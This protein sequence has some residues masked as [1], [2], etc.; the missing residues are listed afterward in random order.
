MNFIVAAMSVGRMYAQRR[1]QKNNIYCIAP[2]SIN[3][4]GSIDCHLQRG[5]RAQHPQRPDSGGH[6]LAE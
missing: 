6:L 4:S 5:Q 3:V 2:R 1:L